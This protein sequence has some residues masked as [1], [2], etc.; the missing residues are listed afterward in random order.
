MERSF[1]GRPMWSPSAISHTEILPA[2][3]KDRAYI[4]KK[5]YEVTDSQGTV[6]ASEVIT[7][8]VLRQLSSGKLQVRQKPGPSNAL[9]LVKLMFPNEYNV[10]LHSTPSAALFSQSR[11]DFSHGCIRVEKAAEL[12]AWVLR[13]KPEWTLGAG[14]PSVQE[15][16]MNYSLKQE[17]DHRL[18]SL[19]TALDR[20]NC[21][22]CEPRPIRPSGPCRWPPWCSPPARCP[23]SCCTVPNPL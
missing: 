7:D 18:K 17:A 21:S 14:D 3:K 23:S 5:G 6:V 1:N 22:S 16:E 13:D 8:D 4:A 20:R 2:I 10:Y 9:G 11:R 19:Q 12:A 15:W